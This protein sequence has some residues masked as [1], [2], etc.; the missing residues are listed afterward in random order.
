MWRVMSVLVLGLLT[1]VAAGCQR[2]T[3][4]IDGVRD[5]T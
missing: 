5:Y 1:L 3:V 2:S 4:R